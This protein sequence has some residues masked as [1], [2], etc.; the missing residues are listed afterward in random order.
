M[1][2]IMP[3]NEFQFPEE[4]AF[5]LLFRLFFQKFVY[6]YWYIQKILTDAVDGFIRVGGQAYQFNSRAKYW[7]IIPQKH[8]C[9]KKN[10]YFCTSKNDLPMT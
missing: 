1:I 8:C 4:Q 7:K 6:L 5:V 9:I 10:N 2:F 3:R